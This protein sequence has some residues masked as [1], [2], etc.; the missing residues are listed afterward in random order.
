[1]AWG[2]APPVPASTAA[3][4]PQ[5]VPAA[6]VRLSESFTGDFDAMVKR[7]LIRVLTPYSKTGYF[8]HAGVTRGLVYDSFKQ[9]ETELNL[10]LKTGTLKVLVVMIPTP[11]DQLAASLQAGRGDIV[12]AQALVTEERAQEMDFTNP[13]AKNV[14]ELIVTGPGGPEIGSVDDLSG[15]TLFVSKSWAYW[16]DV[17]ALSAKFE[18]EGKQPIKLLEAPAN[19]STEDL[20]EMVN[21]GIAP[22]TAAHDY[23]VKFWAQVFPKLKWNSA[24]A[25][26]NGGEVAWAIRK[27]SPLL[28]EQLNAFIAKYPETSAWRATVMATY[29]KNTKFAKESTSPEARARMENLRALFQKY[30][31]KY[32]LDYLLM[33]AQGFQESTL[34]HSVKSPVGAIGVMQV[35]PGTGQQMGVGDVNQLEPNIHAG[36]KFIRFMMNQ[37][38]GKETEMSPLDKGLF[39]FASYNAGPARIAQMRKLAA[40]RGLNPNV[41]FNNVEVITAEKVGRETVT[42]VSN[43]YKYYVGYRLLMEQ[44]DAATKAKEE[45]KNGNAAK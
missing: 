8:V 38:Y 35:M 12:A 11:V 43:I 32:D 20:L 13:L 41:W 30:G 21:A 6:V 33:A 9:F 36:V 15:K 31:E 25:V 18:K 34:N 16:K 26:K 7:R 37:Y 42:Y 24:A 23:L 5:A 2:Q 22:A 44:R 19:L 1:M 4:S 39:T 40:Q 14:S 45:V 10:K 17:E 28:K 27:N 29:L 3:K